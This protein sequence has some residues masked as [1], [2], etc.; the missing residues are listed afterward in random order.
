MQQILEYIQKEWAVISGA[1]I[2][3]LVLAVM[4]FGVA[5]WFFRERLSSAKDL[6][7]LRDQKISDYEK[8]TGA[9]SPDEAKARMDALEARIDDLSP[10][11]ISA[12]QRQT[13]MPY[14]GA[15]SGSK[16]E[17]AA[18]GGVNEATLLSHSLLS[19]FSNAGWQVINSMVMGVGNRPISGVGLLVL[20][21]ANLSDEEQS[22]VSALGEAAIEFDLQSGSRLREGVDVS[23]LLTH[24]LPL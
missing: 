9:S 11:T 20:D 2:T 7:K 5:F 17:I 19:V 18:E 14:L 24:R 8:K 12:A 21:A 16:I 13:M 4:M 3:F 22:V 10:R 15:Y 23:L 1:P 6:I